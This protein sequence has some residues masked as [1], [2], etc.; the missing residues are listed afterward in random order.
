[1]VATSTSLIATGGGPTFASTFGVPPPIRL[2]AKSAAALAATRANPS[3]K[4]V[5]WILNTASLN[6]IGLDVPVV[7]PLNGTIS[8]IPIAA[9]SND[10]SSDS[11]T[12][13]ASNTAT[14]ATPITVAWTIPAND[15]KV[16]TIYEIEVPY[17]GTEETAVLNL[18]LWVDGTTFTNIVPMAG[19]AI[20]A[21]HGFAGTVK[22][23][24]TF[25]ATGAGGTVNVDMSGELTDS[26]VNRAPAGSV[27]LDGHH[28]ALGY[29]TTASHTV[30]VAAFWASNVAG[31][32]I[33]GI[34]SKFTRCGQLSGNCSLPKPG[35][36][37]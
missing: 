9:P 14:S 25:T 20:T 22:L 11:S 24:L 23:K 6:V 33:S 18:G 37:A 34:G 21:G 28:A 4:G 1:M 26:S 35:V 27:A 32:T 36:T 19:S 29:D 2:R 30:A 8:K 10:S 16:S 12:N 13:T 15:A 17:T 31:E 7:M 5:I 3:T